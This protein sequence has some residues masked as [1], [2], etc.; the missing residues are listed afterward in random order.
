[1][2]AQA[3]SLREDLHRAAL[4]SGSFDPA[5]VRAEMED[6]EKF[7]WV[8]DRDHRQ[9]LAERAR[10]A[11]T[12]AVRAREVLLRPM[13]AGSAEPRPTPTPRTWSVRS[14]QPR[15]PPPGPA[16]PAAGRSTSRRS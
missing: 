14:S 5:A 16:P 8:L 10:D 11:G 3:V 15:P 9:T 13:R 1:V 6:R 12:D 7:A 4:T 2:L